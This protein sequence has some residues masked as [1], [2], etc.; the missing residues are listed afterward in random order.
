M[1]LILASASPR[2]KELIARL[3]DDFTVAVSQAE[4][5]AEGDARTA[6][7]SNSLR[8]AQAVARTHAGIVLGADTVVAVDGALLG[9]PKDDA[10][11]KRM[12][13]RLSGRTHEVITGVTLTDGRKTVT[14]S[15]TTAVTFAALPEDVID[16]YVRSGAAA[17]K[18]GAY[19]IQDGMLQRY[20]T[21]AGDYDN[22]VGLPLAL[23][24]R[25]MKEFE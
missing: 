22:V 2:R 20:I 11:A 13:R 4:E 14:A 18:A 23:T 7:E 19:G 3:T 21:Y 10:D 9:K 16:A 12:L 17:D 8:K 1:R 25:L 15:E 6:A 24:E 5:T